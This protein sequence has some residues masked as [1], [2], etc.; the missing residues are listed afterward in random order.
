MA[1]NNI[2][3]EN[4]WTVPVWHFDIEDNVINFDQIEKECLENKLLDPRGNVL[5]NYGGWQ[6][7]PFYEKDTQLDCEI[8]KLIKCIEGYAPTIFNILDVK[9]NFHRKISNY[10][11]NI[12][13]HGDCN[14]AHIHG[15]SIL[16]GCVYIKTPDNCGNFR[17]INHPLN[18]H[19]NLIYTNTS[20]EYTYGDLTYIPQKGKVIIFPSYLLHEVEPSKSDDNRISIAFN[21][22]GT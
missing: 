6:S 21:F 11:I 4:W 13:N 17:I 20:N 1:L 12:N 8:S 7:N 14:K 16:S 5:S 18:Q 2:N 10:W 19:F 22:C 15:G 3:Q 9:S